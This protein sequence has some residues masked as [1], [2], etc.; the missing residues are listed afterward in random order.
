M[1]FLARL[2]PLQM[3]HMAVGQN[4]R[5]HFGVGAQPILVYFSGDWDVHWWY[6]VLTH[7]H[8]MVVG[9][10]STPLQMSYIMVV[11]HPKLLI[12]LATLHYSSLFLDLRGNQSFP[13]DLS[14][15]FHPFPPKKPKIE[16][17]F[18]LCS[19]KP[20]PCPKLPPAPP[21][22]EA[23]APRSGSRRAWAAA[24]P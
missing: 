10:R 2:T 19:P 13:M 20:S 15:R 23:T 4:Q 7:G 22:P 24:T 8:I 12:T 17:G 21:L 18:S 1:L 5:Y 9:Q 6:G 11:G 14:F 3:S 16:W